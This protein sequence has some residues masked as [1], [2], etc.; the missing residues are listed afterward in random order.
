MFIL[1]K[2]KNFIFLF[3]VG[4]RGETVIKIDLPDEDSGD[5]S[6]LIRPKWSGRIYQNF[7]RETLRRPISITCVCSNLIYIKDNWLINTVCFSEL[8]LKIKNT[9][10]VMSE[11]EF[12]KLQWKVVL[13]H[14]QFFVTL[15][16]IALHL[17]RRTN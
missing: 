10:H 8:P 7:W 12:E 14:F 5:R 17:R 15:A 6:K 16:K 9:F 3:S 1:K 13:V 4:V 11:A 2:K